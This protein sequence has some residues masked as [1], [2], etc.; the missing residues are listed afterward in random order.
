[1]K[2]ILIALAAVT[3]IGA[4][5][6]A[7]QAKVNL[8]IHLGGF[9]VYGGHGYYGHYEPVHYYGPQCQW[10][11]VKKVRWVYGERIVTWRK[12]RVCRTYGYGY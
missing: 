6:S 9:G 12:K 11:K 3:A 8:D 4:G 7:A 2:K 10:V 1:M 5:T